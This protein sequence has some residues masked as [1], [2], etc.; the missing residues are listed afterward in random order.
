MNEQVRLDIAVHNQLEDISRTSAEKLIKDGYVLV[1]NQI[2]TKP[3]QKVSPEDKIEVTYNPV[4]VKIPTIKLPI[5]Y[6]DDDVIVINKPAGILSH[7][8]GSFNPEATVASW[9]EKKY[10]GTLSNRSGIVH[11]L[12]RQTSGVMIV[13][14]NDKASQWLQ[15]QFSTRKVAKTY[16]AIISGQLN[17]N[18]AIIDLPIERNPKAPQSFRVGASGKHSVTEYSVLRSTNKSS[19]VEL[20]PTTG[21]THQLRVHLAYLGHPIVGDSIYKGVPADRLYLHAKRLAITLPSN[22]RQVFDAPLPKEFK[23]YMDHE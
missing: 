15:K 8:K 3:S 19:L 13:A 7:S 17:L 12:D 1:N 4:K 10:H 2:T 14:K 20:R 6:E 23:I 9:L 5:L 11:R 22:K 18:Q 21:R 16:M